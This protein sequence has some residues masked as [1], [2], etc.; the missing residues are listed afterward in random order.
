MVPTYLSW[1]QVPAAEQER[2]LALAQPVRSARK[3]AKDRLYDTVLTLCTG[4]YLGRYV[5]AHLLDRNADDLLRRTLNPLV[6]G[7]RL[8]QAFAATNDPRQAYTTASKTH[9]ASA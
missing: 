5:L 7:G 8:T 4:V 2:L 1:E 6:S 3:T 9:D